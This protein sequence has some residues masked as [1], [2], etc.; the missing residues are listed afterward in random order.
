VEPE[1]G[2]PPQYVQSMCFNGQDLDRSWLSADEFHGGGELVVN[3][4]PTP[5]TWAT[6]TPPPSASTPIVT[7][8]SHP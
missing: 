2:T 4:G 6:S 8:E 1:A 7:K 3:L 5:S